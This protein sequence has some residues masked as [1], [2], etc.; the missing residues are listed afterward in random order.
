MLVDCIT[1]RL[2]FC[3][4][5]P[6]SINMSHGQPHCFI[7]ASLHGQLRGF[8]GQTQVPSKKMKQHPLPSGNLT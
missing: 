5:K 8:E 6:Y 7:E 1:I 3:W 4:K 2:E